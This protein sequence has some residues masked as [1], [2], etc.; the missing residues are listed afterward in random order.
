MAVPLPLVLFLLDWLY[1]R[2]P[3][4]RLVLEK[5][6]FVA[7]ALW[8]GAVAIPLQAK[9]FP[10]TELGLVTALQ[11][12]V[13]AAYGFV[14]YWAKLV[15]PYGLSAFYPYPSGPGL[16]LAY[17]AMP[18]LAL[19]I[20][21]LPIYVGRRHGWQSAPFRLAVFG[22]GFFVL[23]IVLVLQIVAV[24]TAVMADRYSYVASVG[25][26]VLLASAAVTAMGAR[27]VRPLAVAAVAAYSLA[28]ALGCYR[29]VGVWTNSETLWTDVIA[30]YPFV[31][32]DD[33]GRV[34][35]VQRGVPVAYENRGNWY[36]EH[37]DIARA[38]RDYDVLVKA[39]VAESGPYV[40]IGNV[41]AARGDELVRQRRR[42]E[43]R[44][45]YAQALDL[46][47]RALERSGNAFETYLNRGI[48]YAAMGEPERA[49]ADF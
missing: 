27:R 28:L 46:Y 5:V 43:A 2:R 9:A 16:P 14:M 36:R 21:A 38:V 44:A 25:A 22:V 4:V 49:L 42:D 39:G 20:V 18:V 3:G 30:K 29:R 1:G 45:E 24:G 11:R 13:L 19:A 47:S 12:I 8:I 37:G 23:T 35:V 17:L 48:T 10:K 32:A 6:P 15:A 41:H 33:G 34:R 26:L 40:N 31:L 7:L